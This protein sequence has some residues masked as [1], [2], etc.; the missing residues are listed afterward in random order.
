MR[1]AHKNAAPRR[2]C[3]TFA[4]ND[5]RAILDN[6]TQAWSA[7]AQCVHRVRNEKR[8]ARQRQRQIRLIRLI[9]LIR[10]HFEHTCR[11]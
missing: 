3:P 2:E 9:R 5:A 4:A 6:F 7:A 8:G 1:A 11:K 10:I